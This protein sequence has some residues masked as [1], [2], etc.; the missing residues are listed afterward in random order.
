MKVLAFGSC[1][2]GL[3]GTQISF[4]SPSVFFHRAE[5]F[6][7]EEMFEKAAEVYEAVRA[8]G[9]EDGVLLYNLGNSYFKS[10]QLGRAILNYERAYRLLPGDDDVRANLE[11]ANGHIADEVIASRY[12][13]IINWMR[14]HYRLIPPDALAVVLSAVFVLGGVSLSLLL[15]GKWPSARRLIARLLVVG[16]F[17]VIFAGGALAMKLLEDS[18][19]VEGVILTSNVYVRSGPG[20]SSPQLAEVHEGLKVLVLIERDDW[21]QVGLPNGLIGWIAIAHLEVI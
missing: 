21:Y 1:F 19:H 5:N 18:N 3:L 17:I 2:L 7:Q 14:G 8:Q 15:S 4:E 13:P 11:F 10:G 9:I 6:Y 16:S 20:V 12:P